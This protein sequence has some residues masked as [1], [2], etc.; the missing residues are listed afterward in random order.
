M[1]NRRLITENH[2]CYK[3]LL[4][5]SCSKY[6]ENYIDY[7]CRW[8]RGWVRYGERS[9]L[10]KEA[11]KNIEPS[12]LKTIKYALDFNGRIKI[13]NSN[14]NQYVVINKYGRVVEEGLTN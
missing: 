10:Y 14:S 9:R 4:R 5:S 7:H 3:C 1:S 2:P 12:A 6:C 11:K 8:I 13:Y